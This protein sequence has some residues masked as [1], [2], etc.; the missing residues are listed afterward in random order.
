MSCSRLASAP[1]ALKL[2][3]NNLAQQCRSFAIFAGME[4]TCPRCS[5]RVEA[6]FGPN[7]EFRQW[8]YTGGPCKNKKKP[9]KCP[10]LQKA[11]RDADMPAPAASRAL[12]RSSGC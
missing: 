11:M 8:R 9:E 6:I 1:M 12:G 4:I 7:G 3:G 10:T 2:T 5:V